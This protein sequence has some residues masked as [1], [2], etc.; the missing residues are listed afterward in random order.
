VIVK[1]ERLRRGR[2]LPEVEYIEAAARRRPRPTPAGPAMDDRFASR[3]EPDRPH[4]RL[5]L[6]WQLNRGDG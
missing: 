1:V 6:P 5:R 3:P 4:G 2:R